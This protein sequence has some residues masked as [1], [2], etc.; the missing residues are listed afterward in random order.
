M[1]KSEDS[2]ILE[3]LR[4]VQ[5]LQPML[6]KK[7]YS[8][9]LDA[10]VHNSIGEDGTHLSFELTIFEGNDII[11]SFDFSAYDT[12]DMIEATTAMAVAF[13]KSLGSNV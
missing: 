11:K 2:V 13:T 6:L 5:K 8:A 4:E 7:G 10:A 12:P 9:H 3:A 1:T